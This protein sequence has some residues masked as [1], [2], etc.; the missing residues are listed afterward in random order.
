M[1]RKE[2]VHGYLSPQRGDEDTTLRQGLAV[3]D[4]RIMD[5]LLGWPGTL[6]AETGEDDTSITCLSHRSP[7]PGEISPG[8]LVF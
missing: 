3:W 7:Q 8:T 1:S 4:N 5:S 2:R 6:P